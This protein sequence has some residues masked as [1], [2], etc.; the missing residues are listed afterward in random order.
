MHT[1]AWDRFPPTSLKRGKELGPGE[2]T[3]TPFLVGPQVMC[4]GPAW[5]PGA[6]IT[7]HMSTGTWRWT[8]LLSQPCSYFGDHQLGNRVGLVDGQHGFG[9]DLFQ[10][11]DHIDSGI[12][13]QAVQPLVP[14]EIFHLLNNFLDAAFGNHIWNWE[15]KGRTGVGQEVDGR[16]T[17]SRRKYSGA[18]PGFEMHAPQCHG[19]ALLILCH[20]VACMGSINRVSLIHLNLASAHSSPPPPREPPQDCTCPE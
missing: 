7:L 3:S 1:D 19:L 13:D 4:R 10:R 5:V 17:Q 16:Y 2:A 18:S 20:N 6:H 9:G 12:V 15:R 11:S 14:N 8:R